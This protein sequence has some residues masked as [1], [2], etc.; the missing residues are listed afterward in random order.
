MPGAPSKALEEDLALAQGFAN[1]ADALLAGVAKAAQEMKNTKQADALATAEEDLEFIINGAMLWFDKAVPLFEPMDK[2]GIIATTRESVAKLRERIQSEPNFVMHKRE[3][4]QQE[5][6]SWQALNDSK[7]SA[8]K[9]VRELD[10]V[11]V[12]A[13]EQFTRLQQE[14][15]E[16]VSF[17]FKSTIVILIVL[18]ALATQNF[19]SMRLA[20][21]KKMIDLAKLNGIG[22]TLAA[23][24]DQDTALELVLHAMYDKI[25]IESGS[26]YLFNKDND[27]EAKAFLPPKQMDTAPS[28][29]TFVMGEGIIGKAAETKQAIFVPDT[30]SAPDYIARENEKAKALLCVP[31]VDKDILIGVMNFSGDVNKVAFADSDY[32]FVSSVARSLVTT[33]KNIRMVEV[34]EEHNRTLEKKVEE[35]T[36][37]PQ[38]EKRGHRQYVLEHAPG[39]VH[40]RRRRANPPGICGLPGNHLRNQEHRQPSL[41]RLHVWPLQPQRRHRRR[42]LHRS[43]IDHR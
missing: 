1:Q 26:V 15:A 34:I 41:R 38:A 3:Q 30:S 16:S 27:L 21:R 10:G 32:E 43:H 40:H 24:R 8:Q 20:I 25:G 28:A 2:D 29:L 36:A 18:L 11:L 6:L 12:S 23:A 9:A 14:L 39:P 35:R 17:G 5:E 7:T 31:L 19:N 22:G 33:I 4:L 13:D 42:G 37:R